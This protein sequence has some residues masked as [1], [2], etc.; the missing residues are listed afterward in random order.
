MEEDCRQWSAATEIR[1]LSNLRTV[2]GQMRFLHTSAGSG[3][4]AVA[5]YK[6]SIESLKENIEDIRQNWD[7]ARNVQFIQFNASN[8]KNDLIEEGHRSIGT[9]FSK[10]IQDSVKELRSFLDELKDTVEQLCQPST[11]QKEYKQKADKL[12]EINGKKDTWY[13]R[14]EPIRKKFEFI[15]DDNYSDI[16]TGGGAELTEQDKADLASLDQAWKNFSLGLN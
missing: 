9:L 1:Q 6:T 2:R 4:D 3:S 15:M 10:M 7:S 13:A 14:I 5:K 16:S 11:D 12:A 8:M